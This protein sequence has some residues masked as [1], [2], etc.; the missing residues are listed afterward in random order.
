M[1][2]YVYNRKKSYNINKIKLIQMRWRKLKFIKACDSKDIILGNYILKKLLSL[3]SNINYCKYLFFDVD[4][5]ICKYDSDLINIL[6]I[7]QRNIIFS[8][9]YLGFDRKLLKQN[10]EK[11]IFII[12]INKTIKEL[13]K[14]YLKMDDINEI[15]KQYLI[16]YNLDIE[17][18]CDLLKLIL[19]NHIS[20]VEKIINKYGILGCD[21]IQECIKQMNNKTYES[22]YNKFICSKN[23]TNKKIN[24]KKYYNILNCFLTYGNIYEY[25]F[26]NDND[27]NVIYDFK[28]LID[29]MYYIVKNI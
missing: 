5:Y 18:K 9:K 13:N 14:Y 8:L 22:I 28:N 3:E 19:T 10:I 17:N 24:D 12:L 7:F 29:N 6:R 23:I 2:N 15:T 26:Y 4:R 11:Y 25:L 16:I 20:K 21:K 27:I 1:Y